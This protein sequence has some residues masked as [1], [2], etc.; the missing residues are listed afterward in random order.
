MFVL[1][2]VEDSACYSR[3]G[4]LWQ[5]LSV[6]ENV[7]RTSLNGVISILVNSECLMG[8]T[9]LASFKQFKNYQGSKPS[10]VSCTLKCSTSVNR[11]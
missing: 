4:W 1:V 10:N 2:P 11:S 9:E 7:V 6:K 3:W 5:L 8:R